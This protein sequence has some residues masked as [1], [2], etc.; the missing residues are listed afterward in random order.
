MTQPRLGNGQW[1]SRS[2]AAWQRRWVRTLLWGECVSLVASCKWEGDACGAGV[3][4]A[5]RS[6]ALRAE[7]RGVG[8]V[9]R[10][11]SVQ[12]TRVGRMNC[13]GRRCRPYLEKKLISFRG[14]PAP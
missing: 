5:A 14:A 12:E 9:A 10:R 4:V 8:T 7:A 1:W 13:G 6:G 3:S 2:S 11:L